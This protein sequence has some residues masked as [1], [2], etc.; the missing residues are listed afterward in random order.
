MT[1]THEGRGETHKTRVMNPCLVPCEP[2]Q[3]EM[4]REVRVLQAPLAQV[5]GMEVTETV[6]QK[7]LRTSKELGSSGTIHG[8]P[9]AL[10]PTL[11]RRL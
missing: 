4:G 10:G 11:T 3:S 5:K 2:G 7:A 9:A 6:A 1:P 8:E